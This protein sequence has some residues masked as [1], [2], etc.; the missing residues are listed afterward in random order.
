MFGFIVLESQNVIDQRKTGEAIIALC[1]S[2]GQEAP[3]SEWRKF[4][5]DPKAWLHAAGYIY[6]GADAGPNGE[7]PAGLK[8]VPVYDTAD[9]MYVRVPF[10]A[11]VENP[12]ATIPDEQ[13]YGPLAGR[14]PVLL[15]RYFMRKCR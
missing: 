8:I 12:P 2:V 14:F 7:I 13:S 3:E 10:K 15:A 9:T 4:E 5:A 11:F 6:D 1:K